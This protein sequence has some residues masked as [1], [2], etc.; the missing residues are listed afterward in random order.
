MVNKIFIIALQLQWQR[1]LITNPCLNYPINF[2][3]LV[4]VFAKYVDDSPLV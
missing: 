4:K 2:V 3:Q 1:S